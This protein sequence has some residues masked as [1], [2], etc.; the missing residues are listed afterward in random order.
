M[1]EIRKALSDVRDVK[2]HMFEGKSSIF[3]DLPS[4]AKYAEMQRKARLIPRP[5]KLA[6]SDINKTEA[7]N[8]AKALSI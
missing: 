6:S 8:A 2:K 3:G 7:V 5:E 4:P 1:S